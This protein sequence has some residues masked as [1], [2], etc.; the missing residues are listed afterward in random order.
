[1]SSQNAL[2]ERYYRDKILLVQDSSLMFKYTE[3]YRVRLSPR[4]GSKRGTKK[5]S[6]K[7]GRTGKQSQ[8]STHDLFEITE[9]ESAGSLREKTSA[10]SVAHVYVH[11]VFN[12]Q[13]GVGTSSRDDLLASLFVRASDVYILVSHRVG[14]CWTFL[15]R[16]VSNGTDAAKRT[17]RV[18]AR[19]ISI[20]VDPIELYKQHIPDYQERKSAIT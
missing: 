1:L 4:E 19:K 5:K 7:R 3:R 2:Q 11:R 17:E 20:C 18:C 15:R 6:K 12:L 14:Q 8:D 16:H 10:R 13:S 9:M